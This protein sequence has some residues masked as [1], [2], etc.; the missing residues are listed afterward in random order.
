MSYLGSQPNNVKQ[1]TG[2]YAPSASPT[3]T[4][5]KGD[6]S[7]VECIFILLHGNITYKQNF[8]VV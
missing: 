2:L 3:T 5:F 7:F 1:N 6:H 4:L 8:A